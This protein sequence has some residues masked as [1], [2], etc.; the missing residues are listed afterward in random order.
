MWIDLATWVIAQLVRDRDSTKSGRK[1]RAKSKATWYI[2]YCRSWMAS[3]YIKLLSRLPGETWWVSDAG[4]SGGM[5]VMW[6]E[7]AVVPSSFYF[8]R[9]L[10]LLA[11]AILSSNAPDCHVC[12]KVLLFIRHWRSLLQRELAKESLRLHLLPHPHLLLHSHPHLHWSHMCSEQGHRTG[13]TL[14]TSPVST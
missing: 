13:R 6:P 2:F 12:C 1:E 10:Q 14:V 8:S 7:N 5:T 4:Q 11:A 9:S 3:P